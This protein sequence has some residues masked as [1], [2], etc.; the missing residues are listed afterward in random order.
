MRRSGVGDFS[1][2]ADE[3]ESNLS[4]AAAD[5]FVPGS[6]RD[7]LCGEETFSLEAS[8]VVMVDATRRNGQRLGNK[9]RTEE[10]EHIDHDGLQYIYAKIGTVAYAATI[11]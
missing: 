7:S 10:V 1:G 2:E 4:S 8:V 5:S 3:V 6:E 11:I 9:D